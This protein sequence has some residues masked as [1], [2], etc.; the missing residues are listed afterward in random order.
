MKR[1]LSSFLAFL[2]WFMPMAQLARAQSTL[3]PGQVND[4]TDIFLVNPNISSQR[5]N[6]LIIWDNTANWAQTVDNSTGYE[7]EKQALATVID[8]LDNRF[9]VGLMLYTETGGG[10]SNVR[11]AYPRYP[12]RQM[13]STAGGDTTDYKKELI[14]L[15]KGL[16]LINDRG[17]N[18]QFA[19]AM[20]EAYLYLGGKASRAGHGQVKKHSAAFASLT[21]DAKG[22][23][24]SGV[25][26]S[27]VSAGCQKNYIIF[28]TNGPSDSG[29]NNSA[30]SLL[31]GLKGKLNSDPIKITPT[32]ENAEEAN[33]ADEYSR[34]MHANDLREGVPG[35]NTTV[36][37]L[38]VYDQSR[39]TQRATAGQIGL[40]KSM[41]NQS[42]GKA[43][44][45]TDLQGMIDAMKDAF[46]KIDADDSV[47]TSTTLPVSVNVRGTQLNQVYMGVFRP[48]DNL[49]PRW[50]GNLKMY[51]LGLSS[52]KVVRLED[53]NGDPAEGI[54][55]FRSNT[56]VS[57]WTVLE[58]PDGFWDY[59]DPALNGNGGNFDSPDGEKVEKGAAAQQLRMTYKGDQ[60]GRKL[61]TCTGTCTVNAPPTPTALTEFNT[62]NGD[63]TDAALGVADATTRQTLIE[64]IRGTDNTSPLE[65][66]NG[67]DRNS[68]VRP[69][70]HGDVLHSRPALIN[71]NRNNDDNDIIAFYGANDGVF[72]AVQGGNA[73]GA[74]AELWGFIPQEFFGR[75]KRLRDNSPSID[76][77][78]K[79]P[80]FMDGPIGVY[81][82]DN[83]TSSF[84]QGD[85]KL[86]AADGDKVYL[87]VGM[88]RGGRIIYALDVSDPTAPKMLWKKSDDDFPELGYTWSE[89]KVTK[90]RAHNGPVLIMGLGYDPNQD[91]DPVD[92]DVT[93][94]TMG[95]G[96]IVLDAL[97]GNPLFQVSPDAAKAPTGAVHLPEA[98]MTR[99]IPSDVT[100]LDRNS[101][102]FTD[103]IYVGD[104]GGKVWRVDIH[105]SDMTKW[106]AI[107]LAEVG[108]TGANQ[109]KFLYPPDVVFSKEANGT[110]FDAV[111]IGSG[112]REHPF[113]LNVQNRY[114]M[115]K[116]P[117]VGLV[118]SNT[119]AIVEADL[120][121]AT[122][123][124]IQ[125]GDET[126]SSTA[127]NQLASKKGW[128]MELGAGEKVVGG[129]VTLAGT[130]FFNTNQP[131]TLS[132]S[133]L[134]L[135]WQ[136]A[137]S[138]EDAT[139]T[140]DSGQTAGLSLE[141]RRISY[142]GGG[143]LPSPVPVVVQLEDGRL[144]Q[145]VISGP[146]VR[147]PPQAALES[148]Y[149]TYWYITND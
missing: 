64:W 136:Y 137:I 57:H 63:I 105:D 85:G 27:P 39:K 71:Y 82:L 24:T 96:V 139:S 90:I 80:Y 86:I 101:D 75:F 113:N 144:Y 42:K 127:R 29:E 125:D 140:I 56:A 41:G 147:M 11:G 88:R 21:T 117:V 44:E 102:G 1:I 146:Q 73:S 47:F 22:T 107:P 35:S 97:N 45:A 128:M 10:N 12:I 66:P 81:Q 130:T 124:V 40:M 148:R 104:T 53:K 58:N 36:F 77:N 14:D 70:I 13:T 4:D 138:F 119:P 103:R 33:W 141:D 72:R 109:R 110:P 134:G 49:S 123:N 92:S 69:S 51:K 83:P 131:S 62:A 18:A 20:H 30:E 15:V 87:Y 126:Q 116:D 112:D 84:P 74:G 28:I 68:T 61:Y 37:S 133:P 38:A 108:G 79:R 106:S 120:F 25:Y 145:A 16:D 19:H 32:A 23:V 2:L 59:R 115:F 8:Q 129:S 111:L 5:P 149:R 93:K 94:E 143:Y 132:C 114:Y 89:P 46:D 121:N 55:G 17:S 142:A 31:S 100:I 91:N 52:L 78:N 60:S 135:A 34:W 48:D 76:I 65:K 122:S 99:S 26:E 7:L 3:V 6:V 118:S 98:G 50:F 9:N 95:R 54:N 43:Y 67:P